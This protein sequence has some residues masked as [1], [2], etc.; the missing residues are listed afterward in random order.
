MY[1]GVHM[2]LFDRSVQQKAF[3]RPQMVKKTLLSCGASDAPYV[4]QM[5]WAFTLTISFDSRNKPGGTGLFLFFHFQIR[6][7]SP[8][9]VEVTQLA[10]G[11]SESG[12]QSS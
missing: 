7:L 1:V 10:N 4:S 5:T 2:F 6:K 3:G 9:E 11:S 12:T 8:R